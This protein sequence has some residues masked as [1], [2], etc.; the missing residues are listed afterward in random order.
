MLRELA[1]RSRK[2]TQGGKPYYSC[3]FRDPRRVATVMVWLDSSFFEECQRWQIGQFFKIRGTYFEHE[4]YGPQIDAE[5]VRPVEERDRQDGFAEHDFIDHSRHDADGML[6][7]L[8][9]FVAKEITDAPLVALIDTIIGMNEAELKR[10]PASSR[11]FY[12]FAGGWLEHTLNVTRNCA[13]LA[14]RYA[15][16]FPEFTPPLNRDLV[17]AGAVLHDIGRVRGLELQPGQPARMSVPGELFGHIVLAHDLIRTAAADIRD[18]NPELLDLLLHIIATY[19]NSPEFGSQE[20][21]CIPEAL[22]LHYVG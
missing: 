10:L 21:P 6:A 1:D 12:T 5:Q 4:R 9:E 20:L 14:D 15:R 17:I 11:H 13:W 18:L 16:A 2:A 7:E 19:P 22:I 8:R 3:R